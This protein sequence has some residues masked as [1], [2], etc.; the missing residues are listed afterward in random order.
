[1]APVLTSAKPGRSTSSTPAKPATSAVMR[2][3]RMTSPSRITASRLPNSGAENESAVTSASGIIVTPVKKASIPPA[4]TAPLSACRCSFFV[5]KGA[6]P[7]RRKIG[8]SASRPNRL[9]KNATSKGGSTSPISRT[10][11]CI[12]VKQSVVAI[13]RGHALGDRRQSL[14]ARRAS[15]FTGCRKKRAGICFDCASRLSRKAI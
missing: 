8:A 5:R 15:A 14:E 9:R 11:V 7:W 6:T 10:I 3:T 4:C 13:I 2:R 12:V 1:M